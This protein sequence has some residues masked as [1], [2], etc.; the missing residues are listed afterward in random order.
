MSESKEYNKGKYN[1]EMALKTKE[2]T[3]EHISANHDSLII[4]FIDGSILQ[5]LAKE[6]GL[7][8]DFTDYQ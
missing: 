3:I 4:F 6:N 1:L 5:I 7:N 8:V 2:K